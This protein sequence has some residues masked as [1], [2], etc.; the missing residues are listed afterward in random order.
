MHCFSN[1]GRV[2]FP[3]GPLSGLLIAS[4]LLVN[5]LCLHSTVSGQNLWASVGGRITNAQELPVAKAMVTISQEATNRTRSMISGSRGRVFFSLLPPGSYRLTVELQGFRKHIQRFD[6][7]VNQRAYVEVQLQEGSLDEEVVVVA[8]RAALQRDSAA[9][10]TVIENHQITGLPLDGR[11]FYELSL[12][13]PGSAPAAPGSAGSVRGDL[14]LNVS[15]AREDANS[16]LLDG[17]YNIDPKLNTFGTNPPVDAIQEF[18]VLTHSYDA[19][20]GRS[21]GGQINVVLKSGTNDV[22]G[23]VYGFFRNAA[24]DAR[25]FFVPSGEPDPEYRRQQFGGSVGGPL[26]KDRTFLFADYEGRRVRQGI[27]RTT[28]VPTQL[29]RSGDFL[30]STPELWPRDPLTRSEMFPQGKPF[31]GA[32]MPASRLHPIGSALA[33]LYP[34]P[35]RPGSAPNFVSSPTLRDRD[36]Q[37]DF[38]L[39]HSL[40]QSSDLSLRYSFAD[41]DLF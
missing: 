20:F 21:A 13:L 10:G 22:H 28:T 12:L 40:T 2:S 16:F 9:L 24:L 1:P 27:T 26:V 11:N 5:L 23:S 35:N 8:E 30:Q 29:E 32:Q 18:E 19:S 4:I 34:L 17:V 36:D 7:R 33:G 39:D 37:F 3:V 25:N 14:A 38:R 31:P 41:R 15:G 6:L